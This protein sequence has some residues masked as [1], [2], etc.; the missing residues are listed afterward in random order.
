M[1]HTPTDDPLDDTSMLISFRLEDSNGLDYRLA[2]VQSG[3]EWPFSSYPWIYED[4]LIYIIDLDDG[5]V[6]L[7]FYDWMENGGVVFSGPVNIKNFYITQYVWGPDE[8][9]INTHMELDFIRIL[10]AKSIQ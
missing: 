1:T 10:N 6:S 2:L 9:E 3:F 5:I 8:V 4:E 7:N